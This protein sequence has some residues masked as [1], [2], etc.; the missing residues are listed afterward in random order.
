[1]KFS[2]VLVPILA[3]FGLAGV[4][5]QREESAA[6]AADVADAANA[7]NAANAADSVNAADVTN[8]IEAATDAEVCCNTTPCF[9][10]CPVNGVF[11][12]CC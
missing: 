1:M 6:N 9:I 8:S 4:V 12:L 2:M 10:G 7:A 5:R 3:G 11:V